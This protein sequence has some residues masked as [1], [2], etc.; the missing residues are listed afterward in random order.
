[1]EGVVLIKPVELTVEWLVQDGMTFFV[2][3]TVNWLYSNV[4][5]IEW[6][7]HPPPATSQPPYPPP[8]KGGK[9]CISFSVVVSVF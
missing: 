3:H 9:K 4:N 2:R 7:R 5:W 1:M 6:H 8:Q